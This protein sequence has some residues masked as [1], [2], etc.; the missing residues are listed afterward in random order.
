MGRSLKRLLRP[1]SVTEP[2]SSRISSSVDESTNARPLSIRISAKSYSCSKVVRGEE[3]SVFPVEA[4]PLDVA[5]EGLDVPH[6]LGLGVRVVEPEVGDAADVFG[7]AEVQ[8]DGLGVSDRRKAVGLR[9][10][11]RDDLRVATLLNVASDDLAHEVTWSVRVAR[12][13]REAAGWGP[14]H[15][16]GKTNPSRRARAPARASKGLRA[17]SPQEPS[18]SRSVPGSARRPRPHGVPFPFRRTRRTPSWGR[19]LHRCLRIHHPEHGHSMRMCSGLIDINS[20]V[21]V[22]PAWLP[23]SSRVCPAP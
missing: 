11:A 19:R 22:M 3:E 2:R 7:N 9:W 10:K 13:G 21:S 12:I 6:L 23:T 14:S 8:A 15:S 17:R 4:Q 1:G 5:L 20:D 18:S 16:S